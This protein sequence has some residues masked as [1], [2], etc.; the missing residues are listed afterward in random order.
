MKKLMYGWGIIFIAGLLLIG[1]E[2][3]YFVSPQEDKSNVENNDKEVPDK[4]LDPEQKEEDDSPKEKDSEQENDQNNTDNNQSEND[5]GEENNQENQD[6]NGQQKEQNQQTDEPIVVDNPTSLQVIVN[7]QRSVPAG[8]QPP[9]LVEANVSYYAEEGSPKRLLRKEA[10]DALEKLFNAAKKD[11]LDLV[12]V[13]GYRSFE[14]QKQI[15]ENNVAHYGQEHADRFSAKPG[16]SEHQTGLAMDV[17]S[18]ALT[19]VLEQSFIQTDEGQWL[20]DHAHEHGFII[21]YPE[22]KEEITGYSYEPW[23]LRYVGENIAG[24]IYQDQQT[25]EEFF[26]LYP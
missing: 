7:K 6:S 19:A 13:S 18:A 12:A 2:E 5:S 16:T 23:H 14:R 9:N 20:A 15:Y 25:L 1:C 24:D 3:N 10:A 4:I 21:R 17:A 8:F 11:G 26:G 22:G